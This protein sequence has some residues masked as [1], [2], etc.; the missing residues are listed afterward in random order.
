M[1]TSKRI[2]TSWTSSSAG[3]RLLTHLAAGFG[4]GYLPY[5]P[6]ALGSIPG[7]LLFL[8]S[9]NAAVWLQVAL[10][11]LCSMAVIGICERAERVSRVPNPPFVVI[12]RMIGM[13]ACLLFLWHTETGVIITG[14][15]LFHL[16]V[17]LKPFPISLFGCFPGGIGIVA[18][19]LSAGIFANLSLRVLL[20]L[21]FFS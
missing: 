19:D 16:L 6:G 14:L 8:V 15:V 18:D 2:G 12:D 4:L 17:T 9:K 10:F 11:T 7:V 20:L 5:C 13:W 1:T 3:S 21:G